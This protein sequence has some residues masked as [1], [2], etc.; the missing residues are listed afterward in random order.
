MRRQVS[1]GN[2]LFDPEIE[3]TARRNNGKARKKK[4]RAKQ[5]EQQER[6]SVSISSTSSIAEETMIEQVDPPEGNAMPCHSSPRRLAHLA[7]P[8]R[9]AR[10]IGMATKPKPAGP[11]RTRSRVNG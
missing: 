5:R 2:L 7:R 11:T 10:Q 4:Q 3:R 6:S 8:P 1:A 9:G